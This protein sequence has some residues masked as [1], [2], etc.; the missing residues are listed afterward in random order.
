MTEQLRWG[1]L[2]GT[3][4]EVQS[5]AKLWNEPSP[6]VLLRGREASEN[7]LRQAM[8]HRRYLH[9]ATHGF[10]ADEEFR[11]MFG[12]DGAGEHLLGEANRLATAAHA[13]VTFRNPL[14]LSGLVLAGANLPTETDESE[15]PIGQDGILTAEEIASLDLRG[16]ELV[17]LSACETG[18]GRVAGG[19]G[20]MGL[21]RAFHLA[22]AR[23]VV[24]SLWKVDDIAT[25]ALMG[26]FYHKLWHED[27]PPVVAL[28]EAQLALY[29]NPGQIGGLAR[30]RGPD[31][32]NKVRLVENGRQPPD[33]KTAPAKLWA[34]F[35]LS[36]PG[37]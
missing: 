26:L 2:P 13:R 20:V 4:T 15:L 5:V 7:A 31:F 35:V 32:A 18:L 36:G 16:T 11:S 33:P 29:R 8:P 28:R 6:T 17:V 22:G 1:H 3:E 24:A 9:L 27:K 30:L 23:N 14:I 12:R 34:S 19:E 37:R 25:A 10:F 21:T